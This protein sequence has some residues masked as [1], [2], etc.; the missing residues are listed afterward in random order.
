MGLASGS[1][2]VFLCC[3]PGMVWQ[4]LGAVCAVLSTAEPCCHEQGFPIEA[5]APALAPPTKLG[6]QESSL[7]TPLVYVAA[8]PQEI[9]LWDVE[10]GKCHQ[11]CSPSH[12]PLQSAVPSLLP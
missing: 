3:G 7:A 12:S 8:G 4:K 5:L 9:G 10:Q 11:V 6:L 2:E 1:R